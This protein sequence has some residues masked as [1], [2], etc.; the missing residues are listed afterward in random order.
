MSS[1]RRLAIFATVLL[2][3]AYGAYWFHV[4]GQMRKAV[5]DWASDRRA[6]G[7]LVTWDDLSVGGFPGAVTLRVTSPI[8][9]APGGWN[10]RGERLEA[11]ASPFLLRRLRLSAPGR[12]TLGLGPWQVQ[13][14]TPDLHGE[15]MFDSAGALLSTR[16]VATG[17]TLQEPAVSVEALALSLRRPQDPPAGDRAPSLLFSASLGGL[18]LPD[19]PGL[20][21]ERRVARAELAG[22][23]S[24]AVPPSAP[25]AAAVRTWSAAG[26]TV[27]V[28]RVA[29]DWPP[30]ELEGEGTLAFDPQMQPLAAFSTRLR[31]YDGL[32]DALSRHGMVQ[33]DAANAAKMMLSL[34]AKPDNQGRA[35]IQVPLT[36]QSGG[37]WL[38][39]A[40]V[41]D[42]PPLS[43]PDGARPGQEP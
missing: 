16:L 35:A 12:H 15:L 39:P 7:W 43:W 4:A 30:V 10:W 11:A 42:V 27:E 3:A 25:L 20:V 14:A 17:L 6:Q 26:G 41:A 29:V 21:M 19:L 5:E 37:L 38:G 28:S 33:P 31:G 32:M 9:A 40:R 13:A 2:A 8:L 36:V 34:L 23:V 1:V 22:Q 24:G 18:T